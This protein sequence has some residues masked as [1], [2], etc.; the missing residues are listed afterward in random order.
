MFREAIKGLRLDFH[1]VSQPETE[2]S[3]ALHDRDGR[4]SLFFHGGG[5]AGRGKTKNLI[6]CQISENK[7][8][9]AKIRIELKILSL[10]PFSLNSFQYW[11]VKDVKDGVSCI[12]YSQAGLGIVQCYNIVPTLVPSVEKK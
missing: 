3:N 1:E 8:L 4:G 9:L 7:A 2:R 12:S 6:S 10:F 11:I 5:G